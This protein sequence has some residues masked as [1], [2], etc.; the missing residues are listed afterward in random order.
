LKEEVEISLTPEEENYILDLFNDKLWR[1]N[2]LYW[3]KDKKG[4]VIQFKLNP[5]QEHFFKNKHT[6]NIILKARQLGFTTLQC[7]SFLDDICFNPNLELGIIAHK[8][9]DAEEFFNGKIKFAFDRIPDDVKERFGIR[10]VTDRD[11]KLEL[12]NGSSVRVS[13]SFRSG[14]IQKLHV[15]EYAKLSAEFPKKAKEIR[16]GAFNAVDSSMEI[17]VESTAEGMEGEFYNLWDRAE[18]NAGKVLTQLDFKPF[19]FPWWKSPDYR[20]D[21]S[22]VEISP[23]LAEYFAA[24]EKDHGVKLDEHQKAW[25][26]KKHEEQKEDT[27]QEYP[28][29]PEE[30][31]VVSGRPVFDREAIAAAIKVAKGKKFKRGRFDHAGKFQEEATGPYKIFIDPEA[32]KKYANGGDVAE[33]LEDGDF[34][35]QFIISKSFKQMASYCDHIHPKL[36][37]KEMVKLGKFY[38]EALLA[39][40]SNNHGISTIDTITDEKYPVVFSR[41]VYDEI[42]DKFKKKIGWLTNGKT[43]P[44]MLDELILAVEGKGEYNECPL[45]IY[46]LQ[47]LRQMLGLKYESDGTVNL[48]GKDLVVCAA[49]ALQAIKQVHEVST[50]VH[51]TNRTKQTFDKLEDMLNY[52]EKEESYF[53]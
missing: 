16:T 9:E 20:L 21:P 13:T 50:A 19:F 28:S 17:T 14:T 35:T 29:Y 2:N 1:L 22:G 24:L 37:G 10:A 4:R 5:E 39:P 40:E 38:N 32:D 47:T 11:G 42:A 45:E 31:F 3:I 25:Y 49:I 12:S 41:E 27:A 36:F 15:S 8:L 48:N 7:V 34:S 18:A 43:K 51:D 6:R 52:Q 46:D 26:S 53:D 23:K 44:L 33:G 30:A